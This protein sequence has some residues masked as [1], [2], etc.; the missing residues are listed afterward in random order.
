MFASVTAYAQPDAATINAPS[1]PIAGDV[2]QQAEAG[3]S[4]DQRLMKDPVSGCAIVERDAMGAD[5]VSWS[6][7]CDQ[8]RASGAGTL[9]LSSTG[10]VIEALTG[11]FDKGVL[12]DG[13]VA[14]KW[15]DGSTYEG[16]AASGRM[17][18]S[19]TLTTAAGD[20]FD[21]QF[22]SGKL[23][24]RGSAIWANGDRYEGE[25]RDG[26][27]AGRGVQL[28]A[29]GRKY[30]GEWRDD[31]PNGHG[32][33][34]NKDG[35]RFEGE[36]V[37]GQ[38]RN[39]AQ[40]AAAPSAN[41]AVVHTAAVVEPAAKPT[42]SP[43]AGAATNAD[44]SASKTSAA[45]GRSPG[46]AGVADKKLFAVDGSSLRMT[47]LD[48]GLV[49]EITA[50]N[51]AVKKN[52]FA[53][54]NDKLGSISEGDDADDVVGVFRLTDKGIVADY[55]DGRNET[56]FPNSEGGVSMIL[57][58]PEGQAYCMAWYPEGHRFSLDERKAALN[59]YA[60]HLGIAEPKRNRKAA[61]QPARPGCGTAAA[62]LFD[63]RHASEMPAPASLARAPVRAALSHASDR[64]RAAAVVPAS[65]SAPF[66]HDPLQP[67]AVRNSTVHLI[68]ADAPPEPNAL[69]SNE[70]PA[71]TK[72]ASASSCL[73]V[74]SDGQHWAF[75]NRCGYDVQFAYCLMN[76]A[77][78]LASCAKGAVSGSVS[79][80]G[81]SALIA[82]RSL[83]ETNA[84]HDF[85]WVACG[86]GA[87]EVVVHLDQSDPPAGRCVRLGAS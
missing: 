58:A 73:N 42:A 37:D 52:L 63:P 53:F 34:T 29:D 16:D 14:I 74:E 77:D 21:G 61:R 1:G 85:R 81:S 19:G 39:P 72:S 15:P 5:A 80:N 76:V 10:K 67:I 28:W 84:D 57:H 38:P 22:V 78:P 9:T 46:I 48:D 47:T 27:A 11:N 59:E 79:P 8:G 3:A 13:H 20:R 18:G 83:A 40:E 69:A 4:S 87:G 26:K 70:A 56:L 71:A 35:S 68:D 24:G 65:F 32:I 60:S 45:L 25:W 55:N 6:G 23:N 17:Q 64:P 49:R 12:R 54:L 62:R 44:K 86:G 82:D 51:G 31:L 66:A 7:R 43:D 41:D 75:R 36:F 30:D 2:S 33:A 50:P